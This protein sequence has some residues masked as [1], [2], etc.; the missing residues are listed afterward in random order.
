MD[1]WT[2]LLIRGFFGGK[3]RMLVSGGGISL[4]VDPIEWDETLAILGLLEHGNI[5]TNFSQ[6]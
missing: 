1:G 5:S 4:R 6:V 3:L 2:T